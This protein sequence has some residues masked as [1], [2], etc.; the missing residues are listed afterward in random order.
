[1]NHKS[2][3]AV[4]RIYIAFTNPSNDYLARLVMVVNI[5]LII[6]CAVFVFY[7]RLIE[8]LPFYLLTNVYAARYSSNKIQK[9]VDSSLAITTRHHSSSV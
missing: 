2:S 5:V 6:V 3:F 4:F 1:M 9:E 8:A 7:L